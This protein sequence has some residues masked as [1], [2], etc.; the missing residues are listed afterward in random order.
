V[1]ESKSLA[2]KRSDA[3]EVVKLPVGRLNEGNGKRFNWRLERPR[4]GEWRVRMVFAEDWSRRTRRI[5]IRLV[6]R[7]T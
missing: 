1:S 7:A 6:G 2:G 3:A 4:V 5:S